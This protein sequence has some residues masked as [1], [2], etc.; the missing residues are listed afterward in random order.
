MQTFLQQLHTTDLLILVAL[1]GY[2]LVFGLG[3]TIRRIKAILTNDT[4]LQSTL[5]GL[6]DML[7]Y[8]GIIYFSVKQ[9]VL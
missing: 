2:G 6:L 3:N 4:L 9:F 5:G 8:C 7:F 1:T